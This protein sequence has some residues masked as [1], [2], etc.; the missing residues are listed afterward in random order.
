VSSLEK[1][2]LRAAHCVKELFYWLSTSTS[3]LH[4]L[5]D[6]N[7]SSSDN[8]RDPI[9]DGIYNPGNRAPTKSATL[10]ERF[11]WLSFSIF[12]C[13]MKAI[14]E[15]LV[16][17]LGPT[18]L[19]GQALVMSNKTTQNSSTGLQGGVFRILD[20]LL[21]RSRDNM[22]YDAVVQ[23]L[24]CQVFYLINAQLVNEVLRRDSVTPSQGF[25]IKLGVSKLDDWV[26][27]SDDKQHTLAPAGEQLDG[28]REIASALFVDKT[29]FMD[30]N[31]LQSIFKSLN[32][33]QLKRLLEIWTPDQ[34]SPEPI[35]ASVREMA[36][37]L[38]NFPQAATLP[39]NP[40]PY[41]IIKFTPRLT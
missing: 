19:D 35:P 11:E 29:L 15:K 20:R 41:Q 27:A 40:D 3:I 17:V 33:R 2:Y 31:S 18:I 26:S 34:I 28:V 23:Q 9:I 36:R 14:G 8:D 1:A 38:W 7:E 30:P 32:L 13:L 6:E 12:Q 16:T 22:L 21:V 5:K 37:V 24:F 25:K 39:L 10:Q 4:M